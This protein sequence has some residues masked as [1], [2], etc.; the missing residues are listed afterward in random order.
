MLKNKWLFAILLSL[1]A[2]LALAAKPTPAHIKKVEK[3]LEISHFDTLVESQINTMTAA[4]TKQ[5]QFAKHEQEF[6]ELFA[7]II[8]IK[9][10]KK[11]AVNTY[12]NTFTEAEI[13]EMIKI[14]QSPIGQKILSKTPEI[15][16]QLMVGMQG[17]IEKN[18]KKLEELIVKISLEEKEANS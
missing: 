15:T 1:F 11:E 14:N 8:D 3:L 12:A 6:K 16:K 4:L 7:E 18:Q 17:N 13:D 5:P 2:S 9:T 10:F